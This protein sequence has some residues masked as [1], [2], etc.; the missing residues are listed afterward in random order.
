[1]ND[2]LK[3]ALDKVQAEE[4]LKNNTK[5]FLYKKTVSK[6]YINIMS[7]I[8]KSILHILYLVVQKIMTPINAGKACI[9]RKSKRLEHRNIK[10][11]RSLKK[12]LTVGIKL[13]KITLCKH[14]QK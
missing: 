13:L 1:M 6:C 7:T 2:R 4:E 8:G 10:L 5:A 14:T 11:L 12:R 3:K 9:Y